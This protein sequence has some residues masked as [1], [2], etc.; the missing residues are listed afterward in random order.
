MLKNKIKMSFFIFLILLGNIVVIS[1]TRSMD[2]DEKHIVTVRVWNPY[3]NKVKD[4]KQENDKYSFGH[5]SL[6]TDKH[7]ISLW[8]FTR[9][10]ININEFSSYI[11]DEAMEIDGVKLEGALARKDYNSDLRE[12]NQRNPER[13]YFVLLNTNKINT[14]WESIIKDHTPIED[15]YNDEHKLLKNIKWSIGKAYTPDK[16]NLSC[17]SLAMALL[18][19][20]QIDSVI[21]TNVFLKTI[22]AQS[23][24]NFVSDKEYDFIKNNA[25]AAL[26]QI[27]PSDVGDLAQEAEKRMVFDLIIQP[28]LSGNY[29]KVDH[30]TNFYNSLRSNEN[31]LLNFLV[32]PMNNNDFK[33]I[34]NNR[35]ELYDY[36]H[37]N[38]IFSLSNLNLKSW[39]RVH[40][41]GEW[42]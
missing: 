22:V 14:L 27:T 26:T 4:N 18:R 12:E 29:F 7:Y 23:I 2:Q 1:E 11:T 35:K 24:N 32:D 30:F 34:V 41:K 37:P 39:Y 25:I 8:P 15:Q 9:T 42:K 38:S 36:D 19:E 16:L 10:I 3:I 17:S 28:K 40:W 33:T 5:V 13:T 31:E 6:Q 21:S 20:G